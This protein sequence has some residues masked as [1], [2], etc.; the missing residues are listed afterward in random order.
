MAESFNLQTEMNSM[1]TT[2]VTQ[3]GKGIT[4]KKLT[5]AWKINSKTVNFFH[6]CKVKW[7]ML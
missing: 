4:Y 1:Q 2:V 7:K 6:E 5:S 3:S